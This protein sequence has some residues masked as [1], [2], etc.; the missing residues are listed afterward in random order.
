LPE[1]KILVIHRYRYLI[2]RYKKQ[3]TKLSTKSLINKNMIMKRTLIFICACAALVIN[4][5]SKNN[6]SGYTADCST[7]KTFSTDASPV[8]QSYCAT[9]SGCH[10]SGSSQGPGALTTYAQIYSARSAIRTSILNGS[11]PQNSSLTNAQ[12][13]AVICW[14]DAGASDN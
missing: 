3:V 4:A 12:K 6:N 10:A 9:S 13:N 5:C 7:T 11:M 14:I 1:N 8:I 2:N